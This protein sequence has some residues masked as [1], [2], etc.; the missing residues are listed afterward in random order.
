MENQ[1]KRNKKKQ[2]KVA[3][4]I[5]FESLAKEL[6]RNNRGGKREKNNRSNRKNYK[7]N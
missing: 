3:K 4:E 5:D 6:V 7:R 1:N 2:S